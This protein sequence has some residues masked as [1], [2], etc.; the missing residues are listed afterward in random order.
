MPIQQVPYNLLLAALARRAGTGAHVREAEAV[1]ENMLLRARNNN[2]HNE[3]TNNENNEDTNNED[4]EG[5]AKHE[6]NE[7]PAAN[8][9]SMN[10]MLEIY[11]RHLKQLSI[12]ARGSNSNSN[13]IDGTLS[14]AASI[15]LAMTRG[16]EIVS[17]CKIYENKK[18]HNT[19]NEYTL[20]LDCENLPEHVPLEIDR[21]DCART[22]GQNIERSKR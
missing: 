1:L 12:H 18:N 11:S 21:Y 7:F 10:F 20:A 2:K 22:S 17:K 9:V 4:S 14:S 5:T 19:K 8:T 3:H 16:K 15:N 13:R 6:Y